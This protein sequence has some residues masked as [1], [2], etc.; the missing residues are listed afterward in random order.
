MI[1][2]VYR[3]LVTVSDAVLEVLMSTSNGHFA[4]KT[5]C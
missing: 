5:R 2:G 1:N 3:L 4:T